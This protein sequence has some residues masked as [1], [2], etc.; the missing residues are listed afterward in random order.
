MQLAKKNN[1]TVFL[2]NRIL[3]TGFIAGTLDATAAI[4][5]FYIKTGKSPVFVFIYVASA[6]FGKDAYSM[7]HFI[8][9]A[10]LLFHYLIATIFSAFYFLI[11]PKIKFLYSNKVSSAVFYGIF[12][13]LVMNLAVVPLSRTQVFPFNLLNAVI[14]LIILIVCIGMPVSF[15]AS[16]FYRDRSNIK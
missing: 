8:A 6:V 13:W 11:Y 16:S 2:W 12:V 15:I 7:N 1:G 9:F 5:Q 10:G 3:L 4:I 14:A